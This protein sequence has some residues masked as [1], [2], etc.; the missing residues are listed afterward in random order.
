MIFKGSMRILFALFCA[1]DISI[2]LRFSEN[3]LKWPC[4][5]MSQF[6]NSVRVWQNCTITCRTH[7]VSFFFF[8]FYKILQHLG[9]NKVKLGEE[10]E[11]ILALAHDY[12]V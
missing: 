3:T 2:G 1:K 5:M 9:G 11:S 7:V 10:T 12:L 8:F 6:P 4:Y